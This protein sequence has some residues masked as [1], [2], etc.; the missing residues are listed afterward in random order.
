MKHA[1]RYLFIGIGITIFNFAFYSI[2][3]NLIFKDQSLIWLSTFIS[4]AVTTLVA[5]ILHSKITWKERNPGKSGIYKFFIWNALLTFLIN[6]GLTQL[7]SLITPLYEFAFN[8][9]QN[10]NLPFTY[11]FVLITGAFVLTAII[12]MI[13]NFLFYDRFVFGKPKNMVE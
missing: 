3:A 6:P 2:L 9:S 1:A 7:F 4:T 13:L 11:D 8:I 10:L 12:T 5:Y